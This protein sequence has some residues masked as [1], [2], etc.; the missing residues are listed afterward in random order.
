MDVSL[1]AVAF[2]DGKPVDTTLN[3]TGAG[4]QRILARPYKMRIVPARAARRSS[5]TLTPTH[6]RCPSGRSCLTRRLLSWRASMIR[7]I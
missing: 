2:R 1:R 6:R 7:A 4:T 3:L 5:A